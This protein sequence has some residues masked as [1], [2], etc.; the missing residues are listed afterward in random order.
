MRGNQEKLVPI[1]FVD[2]GGHGGDSNQRNSATGWGD[3]IYQGNGDG[4]GGSR[5][6]RDWRKR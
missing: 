5:R 2:G 4:N 1:R 3:G 6:A